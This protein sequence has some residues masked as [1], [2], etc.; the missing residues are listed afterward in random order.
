MGNCAWC[1]REVSAFAERCP[2]CGHPDPATPLSGG[3]SPSDPVAKAWSTLIETPFL[4]ALIGG[5]LG[6]VAY[7][8]V[9]I[10]A[11]VVSIFSAGNLNTS[12]VGLF[13]MVAGIVCGGGFFIFHIKSELFPDARATQSFFNDLSK[14]IWLIVQAILGVVAFIGGVWLLYQIAKMAFL[15]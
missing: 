5:V 3:G 6:F 14:N 12:A 7:L 13:A 15:K 1:S 10:L 8:G 4:G 2:H 11:F 9:W